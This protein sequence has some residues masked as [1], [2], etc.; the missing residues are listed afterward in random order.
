MACVL[1]GQEGARFPRA[2]FIINM[3]YSAITNALNRIVQAIGNIALLESVPY[4]AD[5]GASDS[6]AITLSPVPTFY[7][8]GMVVYFKANTANIGACTLNVN[9]L[10]AIAIKKKHDQVLADNDI[11]AGQIVQVIY[12]GT[13]FQ[14]L[15][16]I[17]N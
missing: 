12:D 1:T 8:V 2:D 11:E 10:G 3:E 15:S 5:V 13:N 7:F 6:Y 16:Q 14:M 9:S 17:A 4:G